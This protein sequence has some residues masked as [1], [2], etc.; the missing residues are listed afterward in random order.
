MATQTRRRSGRSA[1]PRREHRTQAERSEETVGRLV[2]TA[3]ELFAERGF[4]AT[5]IEDIVRSA[6]VTRGALYHHFADKTE[7]FRAVFEAEERA[8]ASRVAHASARRR[9]PWR[10]I[11]AGCEEFLDA[12]GQPGVRKILLIE[13]PAVLG[14]DGVREIQYRYG[15]SAWRQGL[16]HAMDEG[17]LRKRPAEPLAHVLFGALCEAAM[18]T[19]RSDRPEIIRGVRAEIQ[20]LVRTIADS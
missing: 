13:G 17:R 14:W 7:L 8:L 3:R 19:A 12:A 18:V 4:A 1:A 15:L 5:S 11:E 20:H 9:D 10:R 2:A 16:E 6:G